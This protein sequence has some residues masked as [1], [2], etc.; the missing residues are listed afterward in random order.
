ME[1]QASTKGFLPDYC[2]KALT[3]LNQRTLLR[4]DRLSVQA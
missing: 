4:F 2:V 3:V 1:F